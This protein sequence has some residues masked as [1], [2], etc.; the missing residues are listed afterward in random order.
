MTYRDDSDSGDVVSAEHAR[1]NET[2]LE[3]RLIDLSANIVAAYVSKN[4]LSADDVP[5]FLK[6]LHATMVDMKTNPPEVPNT[7]Q[8]PAV[9]ISK[10][11]TPDHLICL[12]D[13]KQFK[14]LRRHL[15]STYRMT[16][17]D[18]REK[19]G[20]PSDYPMVAPNYSALRSKV[21]KQ[22]GLGKTR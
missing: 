20:L 12:E 4:P 21:A 11:V 18:Y 14:S 13:G 8:P 10:S 3:D 5:D 15:W 2:V 7:P 16:P 19:W 1:L 9:P 22:N 17:E 6:K